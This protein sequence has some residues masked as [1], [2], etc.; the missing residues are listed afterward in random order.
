[1]SFVHQHALN[2]F[3]HEL[4]IDHLKRNFQLASQ[5]TQN[6]QDELDDVKTKFLAEENIT[7]EKL[8][9]SISEVRNLKDANNDLSQMIRGME[10]ER[11]AMDQARQEIAGRSETLERELKEAEQKYRKVVAGKKRLEEE[12]HTILQQLNDANETERN[13]V[14]LIR[15]LEQEVRS[16]VNGRS[17]ADHTST[18]SRTAMAAFADRIAMSDQAGS[19]WNSTESSPAVHHPDVVPS[20]PHATDAAGEA[21]QLGE[22]HDIPTD[23]T[24]DRSTEPLSPPSSPPPIHATTSAKTTGQPFGTND[25]PQDDGLGPDLAADMPPRRRRGRS[26]TGGNERRAVASDTRTG[27]CQIQEGHRASSDCSVRSASQPSPPPSDREDTPKEVII[28]RSYA[29]QG[30]GHVRLQFYP[31]HG[32]L[33]GE[34]FNPYALRLTPRWEQTLVMTNDDVGGLPRLLGEMTKHIPLVEDDDLIEYLKGGVKP[35]EDL[36][37]IHGAGIA[38]LVNRLAEKEM[39]HGYS[40]TFTAILKY[41]LMAVQR[42]CQRDAQVPLRA[43]QRVAGSC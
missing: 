17:Q 43:P 34:P 36:H 20:S 32:D 39:F 3:A 42:F 41:S 2:P 28:G 31:A 5:N 10:I 40:K 11:E 18:G 29:K 15:D 37:S 22:I 12:K 14:Q 23:G 8:E 16:N 9:K 30:F 33:S 19:Q 26:A 25:V 7:L 4:K 6:I 21:R 35:I 24:S 1:M 38:G 13:N 27:K